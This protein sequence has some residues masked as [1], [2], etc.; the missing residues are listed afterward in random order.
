[1]SFYTSK[2][3]THLV[4][5]VYHNG[6]HVNPRT[7]FKFDKDKVFLLNARM[8][9]L[10]CLSDGGDARYAYLSGVCSLIKNMTLSDGKGEIETLKFVN[11][12]V[13]QSNYKNDNVDAN[14]INNRSLL[15]N[16]GFA[17]RNDLSSNYYLLHD[18]DHT[19]SATQNI[20]TTGRGWVSLSRLLGFFKQINLYQ[21]QIPAFSTKFYKDLTLTIEW[22]MSNVLINHS[23]GSVLE[24]ML[25]IDELLYNDDFLNGYNGCKFDLMQH[26]R[27]TLPSLS[28]IQNN[29]FIQATQKYTLD[30]YKGKFVKELRFQN[31]GL[32]PPSGK[33]LLVQYGYSQPL[34]LEQL[35]FRV[36]GSELLPYVNGIDNYNQKL[37][38]AVDVLGDLNTCQGMQYPM[39]DLQQGINDLTGNANGL[40]NLVSL[41]AVVINQPVTNLDV[42]HSRTSVFKNGVTTQSEYPLNQQIY[43]YYLARVAK[44]ILPMQQPNK[45]GQQWNLMEDMNPYTV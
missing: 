32:L 4:N 29:Q 12:V 14:D 11:G 35:R 40:Q 1:M 10:G 3:K 24:P 21:P 22:N 45:N 6:T 33:Q 8:V 37:G 28:P 44:M 39:S 17:V 2:V 27:V 15:T 25:I 30:A 26:E 18:E 19:M 20:N 41:G 43:V 16:M 36:N 38:M 5:A 34:Y 9:N 13:M 7:V 31:I 42:V 23:V